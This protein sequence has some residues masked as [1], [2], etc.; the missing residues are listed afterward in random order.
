MIRGSA[1]LAAA[2]CTAA[3]AVGCA[4]SPEPYPIVAVAELAPSPAAGGAADGE[5][6][7]A[8]DVLGT[9]L[10]PGIGGDLDFVRTVAAYRV[11]L[12]DGA[13]PWVRLY[14]APSCEVAEDEALPE[15]DL[16]AIRRVGDEPHFVTRD[17]RFGGRPVELDTGTAVAYVSLAPAP[18]QYLFDMIVVV[19]AP[20][21]D[22]RTVVLNTT[23]QTVPAGGPWLACGV[24]TPL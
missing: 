10:P 7:G 20:S 22:G 3:C 9:G 21:D 23:R 12:P 15:Q 19:L 11:R 14:T 2:G 16:G 24:F 13:A 5:I 1:W 17:V 18:V 4:V 8:I 6:T